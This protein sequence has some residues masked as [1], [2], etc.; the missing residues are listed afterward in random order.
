MLEESLPQ[1]REDVAEE[2]RAAVQTQLDRL[3]DLVKWK[4]QEFPEIVR[5]LPR[6]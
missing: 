5:D 1:I 4:Q 3:Q 6:P 2:D